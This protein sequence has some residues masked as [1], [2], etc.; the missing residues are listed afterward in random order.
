MIEI[1]VVALI[2][3]LSK[4]IE[5]SFIGISIYALIDHFQWNIAPKKIFILIFFI[6]VFLDIISWP[7]FYILDITFSVGNEKI[8]QLFSLA[9]NEHYLDSFGFGWSEFVFWNIDTLIAGSIGSRFQ[10]LKINKPIG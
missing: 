9:E 7:V 5:L 3:I 8:A 6:I 4:L 2:L 10:S 1:F